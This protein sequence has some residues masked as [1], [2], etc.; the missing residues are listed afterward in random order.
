MTLPPQVTEGPVTPSSG[1]ASAHFNTERT[2]RLGLAYD[3]RD[4]G[5]RGF[6]VP[7]SRTC[8][9]GKRILQM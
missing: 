4:D 2:G 5:P 6:Q 3:Q 1:E 8:E 9:Y 7:I